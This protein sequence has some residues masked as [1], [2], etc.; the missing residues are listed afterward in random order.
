MAAAPSAAVRATTV[1]DVV[2]AGV[3]GLVGGRVGGEGAVTCRGGGSGGAIASASDTSVGAGWNDT[4]PSPANF[5]CTQTVASAPRSSPGRSGLGMNPAT[6]LL[7]TPRVRMASAN[8][9]ANSIG[10]P[11]A[12]GCRN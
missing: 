4:Q 10:V 8:A 11:A 5:S 9:S 3:G 7:G 6:S 12:P 2:G 1:L